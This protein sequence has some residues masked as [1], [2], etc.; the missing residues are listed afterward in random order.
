MGSLKPGEQKGKSN[1]KCW[2]GMGCRK[3]GSK[4]N[5]QED[6]VVRLNAAPG[7]ER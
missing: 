7:D 5:F 1:E 2:V 4:V 6:R 3:H